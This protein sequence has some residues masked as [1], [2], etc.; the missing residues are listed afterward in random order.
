MRKDYLT[1][2]ATV[3]ERGVTR[4]DTRH[5]AFCGCIDWHSSVHGTYA[6]LV[7]SRLT[8]HTPWFDAAEAVLRSERL[9]EELTCLQCGELDHELPYGYAWFLKLAQERERWGRHSDVHV[10]ATEIATRLEHW[11]FSLSDDDI[12]HYASRREYG[13]VSWAVLN[14]WE[15]SC[16][17]ENTALQKRLMTLTRERFIPL[18]RHFPASYDEHIDEFFGASLQRTRT[19][20]SVLPS[21]EARAWLHSFSSDILRLKPNVIA[22]KPH[23]A[24]L[25]FSRAWAYW[26]LFTTTGDAAYRDLYMDHVVTHME[27][28]EFWRD[29]Y[30]QYSHWV[31]QFGIYA[32]ALS[33]GEKGM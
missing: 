29:D 13:N 10:L 11:V 3:V 17:Q 25:N 16:W 32:I 23:S 2:L 24:G 26:T 4:T 1:S 22:P 27:K 14:L 9:A 15:W 6:L 18:D 20:L 8:G 7:A 5:P 30:K 21:D 31:P 28:T 19:I 12:L 33:M